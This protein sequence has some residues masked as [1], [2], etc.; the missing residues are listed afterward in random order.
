MKR[1]ILALIFAVAFGLVVVI[2]IWNLSFSCRWND[3]RLS[4][5]SE[6]SLISIKLSNFY[7]GTSTLRFEDPILSDRSKLVKIFRVMKKTERKRIGHPRSRW[8]LSLEFFFEGNQRITME[9]IQT[10]NQGC[11]LIFRPNCSGSKTH[12]RNDSLGKV[13]E[14]LLIKG[15]DGNEAN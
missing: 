7:S 8:S 6:E 14:E 15:Q 2:S 5:Y 10:R 4:S 9:L 11:S 3:I 1:N 13:V 12:A